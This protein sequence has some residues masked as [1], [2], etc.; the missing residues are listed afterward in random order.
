MTE[1]AIDTNAKTA[2]AA[3]SGLTGFRRGAFGLYRVL[4]ALYTLGIV[5]QIFLAGQGIY[6]AEGSPTDDDASST[7]DPHRAIGHILTQPVALLVLIVALL[8]R[9]GR[10]IIPL[11]VALFVLGIVQVVLGIAGEGTPFLGGLHAVNAILVLVLAAT[12][13]VKANPGLR[14]TV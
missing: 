6:G 12:L 13:T 11:N 3:G 1:T 14:R 7:L 5:V 10:K 8:A 9:P 2:T 4:I